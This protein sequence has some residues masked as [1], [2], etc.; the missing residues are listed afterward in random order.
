MVTGNCTLTVF[1][2]FHSSGLC[3]TW[4][5]VNTVLPDVV[6]SLLLDVVL[7]SLMK[8]LYSDL[9]PE[10]VLQFHDHCFHNHFDYYYYY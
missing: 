10:G 1:M 2:L 6:C 4:E 3:V 5:G 8:E 7:Y 9:I